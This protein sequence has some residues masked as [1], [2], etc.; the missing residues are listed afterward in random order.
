M[1]AKK[2]MVP[3]ILCLVNLA[4]VAR[5]YAAELTQ[6][7]IDGRSLVAELLV[8]KPAENLDTTAALK[9][10]DGTGLRSEIQVRLQVMVGAASWRSI[11]TAFN[12]QHRAIEEFTVVH[13][14]Q[15]PSQYLL[16]KTVGDPGKL[17]E[18]TAVPAEQMF[19]TAFA[20][21]DFLL[22]DLGLEFFRWPE[23][24][25]VKK[26]MRM[27]RS[28]RVLESQNPRPAPATYLRVLSWIDLE[29]GGLIRAEA[30][31]LKNNI[32]KEFIVHSFSKVN[33]Q[34][35]VK[36]MEIRDLQTD[37]RTLLVMNFD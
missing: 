15:E 12:L 32:V 14:E 30:Y 31:N 20:G 34:W 11:Y 4:S 27:G 13:F 9:R 19:T 26:Q 28:C 16:A 36:K 7:Q 10:T 1:P 17:T 5:C 8:Q 25:L 21:S 3:L 23:Q 37:S 35:Q 33:D 6:A 24:R 2:I 22:G 29:S 18:P